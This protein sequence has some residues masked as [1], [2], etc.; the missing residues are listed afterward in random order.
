MM[1][2]VGLPLALSIACTA[3]PQLDITSP[4][5]VPLV[6]ENDTQDD[7]TVYLVSSGGKKDRMGLVNAHRTARFTL[8][9]SLLRE[10]PSVLVRQ[11]AG[12]E[13]TTDTLHPVLRG[14]SI[15]LEVTALGG[16]YGFLSYH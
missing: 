10:T 14:G 6:I 15:R 3:P 13:W 5:I 12:C 11:I 1:R 4:D 9:L 2:R 7:V 16:I 8:P